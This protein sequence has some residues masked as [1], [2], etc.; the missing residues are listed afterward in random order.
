MW[1]L[2]PRQIASDLRRF[3][4]IRIADWHQGRMSSHELLELFGARIV[5]DPEARTRTVCIDFA[6]ENG[7]VAKAM[8]GGERPELE[9]MVAQA[10]NEMAVIRTAFVPNADTDQYDSRIFLSASR[11]RKY[12]DEQRRMREEQQRLRNQGPDADGMAAMWH[13]REV[14]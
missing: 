3:F 10:A 6:P 2:F 1:R 11:Q 12:E 13:Q 4:G 9:Q 5:D 8:R 14:S 7:A